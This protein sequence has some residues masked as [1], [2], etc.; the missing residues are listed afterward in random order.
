MELR[1]AQRYDLRLPFRLVR[2][3][4]RSVSVPGETRNLSSKGVLFR[5]NS[6]LQVGDLVEYV[7]TLPVQP[8]PK[9]PPS[10]HCLG[11]I[12]RFGKNTDV[13]A[14]LERYEFVR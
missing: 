3:G 7:I 4:H 6:R 8:G 1:K 9:G 11:K 2:Q 12:V 14:T 10:L 13:A 5:S